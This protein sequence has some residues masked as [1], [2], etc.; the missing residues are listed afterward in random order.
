MR[1]PPGSVCSIDR[2]ARQLTS[3]DLALAYRFVNDASVVPHN[4]HVFLLF[5][6]ESKLVLALPFIQLKEQRIGFLRIHSFTSG[7]VLRTEFFDLSSA[8][9][10]PP[11]GRGASGL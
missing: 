3:I 8:S 1:V 5:V 7:D 11:T 2:H 4:E 10:G 6:P 9:Q